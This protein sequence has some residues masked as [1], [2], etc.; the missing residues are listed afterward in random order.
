MSLRFSKT[1]GSTAFSDLSKCC[2][3]AFLSF[4]RSSKP[5]VIGVVLAALTPPFV[6]AQG[7]DT[8]LQSISG[9]VTG[10]Q[11]GAQLG[12][13]VAVD[14]GFAV[15]GAPYDDLVGNDAGVVKIFDTATGALLHVIANPSPADSDTFGN[16]VAISGTQMV[17]GASQDD[18]G[19]SN[20]G[21]VY[22]YDLSGGTP[23]LKTTINN[24]FPNSQDFFGR[25]IAISGNLV[26]VGAHQDDTGANNAGSAYV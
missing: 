14:G 24:P 12:W 4:L 17:V 9:P 15:V 10:A 7:Q 21:S 26:V 25:S 19:A 6:A 1:S 2:C 16:S 13:S 11:A 20:A 8:L 5:P 22:V 18:T 3:K 23:V